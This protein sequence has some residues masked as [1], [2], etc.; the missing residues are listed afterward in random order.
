[1]IGIDTNVLLRLVFGASVQGGD[2][3][4]QRQAIEALVRQTDENFFINHVVLA[5]SMWVLRRRA[6]LSR[7]AIAEAVEQLLD[8]ANAAIQEPAVVRA[9]VQMFADYPGDF[10]DHL[11]GEINKQ[12]GCRTTL[13]FDKAASRSP[14]FSE[15]QR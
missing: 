11:I 8:A 15:L 4:E 5:E 13:T 3:P 1:M 12:S 14:Q 7:Q 6:K 10:S 9:A 2:A